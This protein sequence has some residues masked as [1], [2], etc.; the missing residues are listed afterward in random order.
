MYFTMYT[1]HVLYSV[2]A[3]FECHLYTYIYVGNQVHCIHVHVDRV[4]LHV[5]VLYTVCQIVYSTCVHGVPLQRPRSAD[6][7]SVEV[8]KRSPLKKKLLSNPQISYSDAVGL[9]RRLYMMDGYRK[10]EVAEKL[11]DM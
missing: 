4:H 10:S 2:H 3:H 7:S 9:A 8:T 5:H 1:A 6:V 11:A